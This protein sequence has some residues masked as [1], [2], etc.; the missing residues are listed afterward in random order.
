MRKIAPHPTKRD[1]VLAIAKISTLMTAGTASAMLAPTAIAYALMWAACKANCTALGWMSITYSPAAGA[2]IAAVAMAAFGMAAYRRTIALA[3]PPRWKRVTIAY[4]AAAGAGLIV[5]AATP[6]L[7]IAQEPLS[8]I[9]V[10]IAR[11]I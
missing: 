5:L 6:Y 9:V 1:R 11:Q 3:P 4:W 8:K 2:V 7:H 10:H